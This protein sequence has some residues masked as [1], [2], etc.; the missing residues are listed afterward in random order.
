V[1][2]LNDDELLEVT[3]G[4]VRIRKATLDSGQRLRAAKRAAAA[5][6]AASA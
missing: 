1:P 3:P 4:R 5:D 2:Q 6:E